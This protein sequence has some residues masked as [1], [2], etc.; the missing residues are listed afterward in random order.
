MFNVM[1]FGIVSLLTD[2]SSEMV[3][4]LLPIFLSTALGASPAIIGIIEG[5]AESL[6]S[7]LKVFSGYLADKTQKKKELTITGY[8]GSLLGKLILV[9]A[10][11]WGGV[12]FSRI[13]DRFGKGIRTAPRDALIADSTQKSTRGHAFGLHRAMDTMGAVIGVIIAYIL[14]RGNITDFKRIFWFSTI[15]ALLG[16]IALLFVKRPSRDKSVKKEFSFA[17]SKLDT[18][19][20][21]FLVLAFIFALGNSSNQFLLLRA[22]KLGLSTPNVLLL[23]LAFNISY[24]L[25]SLPAGKLSDLIGRKRVLVTGYFIYAAVYFGFAR[26]TH[27]SS[28]WLLFIVYGLYSAFTDGVE[29]ALLSD[30]APSALR[31]TVIGMHAALVG[32]A[33]LPASFIAGILWDKFGAQAPFYFGAGMG[34]L[35]VI[36]LLFIFKD[37]KTGSK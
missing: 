15:P 30:I 4:P 16:I 9:L 10:G 20:K 32:V 6:A 11:S 31:G 17:W 34:L 23:Y 29:K 8:S 27:T 14:I 12:L 33:L 24:A 26:V 22:S 1:L 7:L 28:L 3:Y 5:I 25:V 21:Q 35:A 19:L 13:I 36:G 37:K 18:K 2:I